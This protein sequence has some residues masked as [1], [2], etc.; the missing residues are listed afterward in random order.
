MAVRAWTWQ[1]CRPLVVS[2]GSVSRS[3]SPTSYGCTT[4]RKTTLSKV[5]RMAAP[6]T[7]EKASSTE[8]TVSHTL[9]TFTC[10]RQ[11]LFRGWGLGL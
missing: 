11:R 9:L 5:L 2:E 6:K 3:T 8:D 1:Y 7:K 4:K 10:R